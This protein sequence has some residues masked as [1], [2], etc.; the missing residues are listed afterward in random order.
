MAS[1][2]TFQSP[3]KGHLLK[4]SKEVYFASC[5]YS[6]NTRH[7]RRIRVQ[8][9]GLEH[10]QPVQSRLSVCALTSAALRSLTVCPLHLDR[11][12]APTHRSCLRG[13]CSPTLKM[14]PRVAATVEAA[15]AA[16]IAVAAATTAAASQE[17]CAP[18]V[19][20]AHSSQCACELPTRHCA[21]FSRH[22]HVASH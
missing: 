6:H 12:A 22:R 3:V 18:R 5:E 9:A 13:C 1:H 21:H 19:H 16:K 7:S 4:R 10:L 2:N 15:A 17:H 20:C 8:L 11:V 14:L